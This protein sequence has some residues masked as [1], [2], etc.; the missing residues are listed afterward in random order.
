VGVVIGGSLIGLQSNKYHPRIED[1]VSWFEVWMIRLFGLSISF[2][3]IIF[4]ENISVVKDC[5][6]LPKEV[7][8][9]KRADGNLSTFV[10]AKNKV[11][12]WVLWAF[13]LF[14]AVVLKV[15]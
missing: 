5:C 3:P 12:A 14:P 2:Y 6:V 10:K 9:V 7:L 8:E 15:L 4:F 13:V 1:S 11:G